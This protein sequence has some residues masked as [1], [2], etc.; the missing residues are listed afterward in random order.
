MKLLIAHALDLIDDVFPVHLIVDPLAGGNA[1][2][3]FRLTFRPAQNVGV[4][5]AHDPFAAF[6]PPVAT[7]ASG[8]QRRPGCRSAT[9]GAGVG[10]ADIAL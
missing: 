1:A 10:R 7:A 3:R 4:V 6:F 2:Q 5:F 8:R 9:W